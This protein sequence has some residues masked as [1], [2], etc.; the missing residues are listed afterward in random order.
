MGRPEVQ[1]SS[2]APTRGAR[3]QASLSR[4]FSEAG[5]KVG[6]HSEPGSELSPDLIVSR[7]GST[8]AVEVKF[9]SEGRSDRLIPLWA[10]AYLQAKRAAKAR[11]IPMAVIV[12]PRVPE[13]V[14]DQV[15]RFA[16]EHAPDAGAG[17]I[18]FTGLRRFRGERLEGLD[19]DGSGRQRTAASV[20]HEHANIFSDL[21][22]WMLKVLLAPELPESLL[23]APRG[24]YRSASELAR[25]AD[26]AVM[27][28]SRLVRQLQQEGYLDESDARLKLVRRDD[29]FR[30]WRAAAGRRTKEARLRFLLRGNSQSQL[31]RILRDGQGCLALFAAA[32]ELNY[33]LVHGVPLQVYV[34]RLGPGTAFMWKQL[35]PVGGNEIPDVI[36]RE[37]PARN[38][39]FR[40]A[41]SR[42]GVLVC[43]VLQVWL[44]VSSHPTRGREQADY[45]RRQ[46]LE[47]V[48]TGD[49]TA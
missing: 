19:A 7:R 38:S 39:V 13:R 6:E 29:L 35:I 42:D 1:S 34:E 15:L 23:S 3:A 10:Q 22:Q 18:D 14:A 21:N 2:E 47:S 33:G 12:A 46:V 37:A 41:V 48:L 5:W 32:E 40:G 43:D 45:I 25:A 11:E 4:L 31:Q 9:A 24:R 44:D 30:R 8:Y 27:T 49:H 26:V 36:I 17:V 16:A 28:A 20:T